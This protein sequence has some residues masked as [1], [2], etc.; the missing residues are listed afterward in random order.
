MI[1]DISKLIQLKYN[2]QFITTFYD[3]FYNYKVE[4][5]R[6]GYKTPFTDM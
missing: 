4:W 5:N 2:S 3:F 6:R 1:S